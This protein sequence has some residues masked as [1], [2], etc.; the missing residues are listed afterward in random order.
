MV[1]SS[2]ILILCIGFTVLFT[3]EAEEKVLSDYLDL[4]PLLEQIFGNPVVVVRPGKRSLLFGGP[5]PSPG[6]VWV[7]ASDDKSVREILTD[8]I[9]S[10]AYEDLMN[11]SFRSI[12][13]K[14][15]NL[16]EIIPITREDF[17]SVG[18]ARLSGKP[19]SNR[20]H[21]HWW[22]VRMNMSLQR[23]STH[24]FVIINI[25]TDNQK[26]TVGHFCFGFRRIGGDPDGD[27]V[28]DF[29]APWYLDRA[30]NLMEGLNVKNDLDI[31]VYNENLYDWCYTQSEYRGCYIDCWFLPVSV[32]QMTLMR[33][34]I[35]R[36]GSHEA[37]KFRGA[38]RNCASL[39]ILFF[40]RLL[41]MD[42][43]LGVSDIADLPV[44][45]RE[46]VIGTFRVKPIYYR[47][48]NVTDERGREITAKSEIHRAPPTRGSSRPYRLLRSVKGI[49]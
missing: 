38:R 19:G 25:H 21:D 32:E 48:E 3:T 13:E 5:N 12:E 34:F 28:F 4:P 30:P 36:G 17:F 18:K 11:P 33:D 37:G 40:N 41:P 29:R 15:T 24:Q 9:L 42:E 16:F 39:G 35:S 23:S 10:R 7:G 1:L 45:A 49:N 6:K 43:E 14:R 31:K 8:S 22:K 47:I 26:K 44:R 20:V 46:K 2:R 27:R